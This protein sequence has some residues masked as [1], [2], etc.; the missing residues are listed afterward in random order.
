MVLNITVVV[1]RNVKLVHDARGI[2]GKVLEVGV[3]RVVE[4]AGLTQG[5]G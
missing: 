3:K 5:R 4:H 1:V 2:L